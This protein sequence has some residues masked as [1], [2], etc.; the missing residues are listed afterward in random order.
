MSKNWIWVQNWQIHSFSSRPK[1]QFLERV[2]LILRTRNPSATSSHYCLMSGPMFCSPAGRPSFLH[3]SFPSSCEPVSHCLS[4]TPQ[5]MSYL[6]RSLWVFGSH[7]RGLIWLIVWYMPLFLLLRLVSLVLRIFIYFWLCEPSY[8][9]SMR[10]FEALRIKE[11]SKRFPKDPTR[12]DHSQNYGPGRSKWS[13]R[14]NK[15]E[16]PGQRA[17]WPVRGGGHRLWWSP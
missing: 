6:H 1:V 12:S 15:E 11:D 5:W 16:S 2:G 17:P 8:V 4:V 10:I 14:T 9:S 3:I 7:F 13:S